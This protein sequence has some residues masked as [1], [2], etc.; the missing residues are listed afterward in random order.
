RDDVESR[1]VIRERN[2]FSLATGPFSR[3][4]FRR[5]PSSGW[6]LLVQGV[7]R[8]DA[9][10]DRLLRRFA[11]VPYAR[12][13]D[14]MVSYATPGG[15]VGPH[16]DSYDVF[17]VQGSGKRRWRV[18]RPRDAELEPDAPLKILRHFAAEDEWLL[19][20]GDLL[21]VPPLWAH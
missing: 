16:F 18:S 10:T 13:D 1:L 4:D 9:A 14:V 5:L 12:L 2:R 7:N 20:P 21:Y 11:F 17:L 6:T 19:E 8:V 3:S 15:G